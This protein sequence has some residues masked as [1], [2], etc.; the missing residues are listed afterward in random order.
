MAPHLCAAGDEAVDQQPVAMEQ[1]LHLG[2]GLQGL[3]RL[4]A[5]LLPSHGDRVAAWRTGPSHL[6][7]YLFVP[8]KLFLF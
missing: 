8:E 5:E 4:G 2:R 7:F 1:G 3:G 6:V